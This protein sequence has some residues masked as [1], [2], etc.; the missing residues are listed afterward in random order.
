[1]FR[2]PRRVPQPIKPDRDTRQKAYTATRDTTSGHHFSSPPSSM[3]D[4]SVL[5]ERVV[6]DRSWFFA[7][8]VLLTENVLFILFEKFVNKI[9]LGEIFY[10]FILAILY[11]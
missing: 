3:V 10:S 6:L 1:M 9:R 7:D 5:R 8:C 11:V 4:T 2:A